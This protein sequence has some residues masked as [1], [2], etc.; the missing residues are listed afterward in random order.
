MLELEAVKIGFVFVDKVAF[1][2]VFLQVVGFPL[3][4]FVVD[5]VTLGQVLLRVPRSLPVSIFP[6]KLLA[7]SYIIHDMDKGP[8]ILQ[9]SSTH[10]KCHAHKILSKYYKRDDGGFLPPS[11]SFTIPRGCP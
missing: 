4:G 8:Q 7:V 10:T 6:S 5:K 3:S 9:F 11:V 1:G 2:Q